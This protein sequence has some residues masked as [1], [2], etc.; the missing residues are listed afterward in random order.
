MRCK[1]FPNNTDYL[2]HM[3]SPGRLGIASQPP[4][5]IRGLQSPK[6]ETGLKSF[7]GLG[8]V[9]RWFVP[10]FARVALP[11]KQK[12]KKGDRK[13]FGRPIKE[14]LEC[15]GHIE[16]E[17]YVRTGQSATSK[18]CTLNNRQRCLRQ[19]N[20]IYSNTRQTRW[21]RETTGLSVMGPD[22]GGTEL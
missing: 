5:A 18:N 17:N 10:N 12:L 9:Y 21:N 3:T 16:S 1:F 19:V 11:F 7:L 20:W 6:N 2:V 4:D 14:R 22:E 8:N 13:T 15:L